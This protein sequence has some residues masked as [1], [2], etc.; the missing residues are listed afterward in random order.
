MLRIT[1]ERPDAHR[2]LARHADRLAGQGPARSGGG[3][4]TDSPT[5]DH[6][7]AGDS[8]QSLS[9]DAGV[10]R[11]ARAG[12]ELPHGIKPSVAMLR[13]TGGG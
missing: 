2:E 3:R 8:F 13:G 11:L 7:C 5:G 4:E 10:L 12:T 1:L 6:F 9:G